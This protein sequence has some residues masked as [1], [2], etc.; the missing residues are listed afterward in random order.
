MYLYNAEIFTATGT[1]I[2]NGYV[3][4]SGKTIEKVSEGVPEKI[5]PEDYDCKGKTLFPGFI[6]AHTHMGLFESGIGIEGED[7]NEDSDPVT[8]NLRTIDGINCLDENFSLALSYGIT[9]V[10]TGVGSAN[11]IGGDV[12]AVKTTG[13]YADEML[14]RVVGIK[15]A[16]G[17]NPKN[18]FSEKDSAPVTRM[19]TAAIIREA[20]FKAKRYAEDK[21]KALSEDGDNPEYD[22]KCEALEPLLNREI[23][24]FFHCHKANDIM[25]AVR[26]A[27]EFDL[28][29]SLVHCTEGHLIADVLGENGA[30]ASVGPIISDKG[31]PELMGLSLNNAAELSKNKVSVSIC[32]DHPEVPIQYLALSAAIAEKNG[33]PFEDAIRAITVN[34]AKFCGIDDIVGTIEKGKIA[35]IALFDENPLGVEVKP[36]MVMLDGK[37]IIKKENI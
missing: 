18:T 2:K 23:K 5:S 16:L 19:A 25:T 4:V 3:K 24:A 27:K 12:I 36:I 6:D 15:F 14:R 29:Y 20:L 17:E 11:P 37:I 33:L 8:P 1:V 26:I 22:A 35:D 30:K 28:D 34:A 21:K 31:K 9:T 10:A 32:T 7:C 13:R